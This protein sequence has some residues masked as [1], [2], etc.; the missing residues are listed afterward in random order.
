MCAQFREMDNN[1][2]SFVQVKKN[3][4]TFVNRVRR[5]ESEIN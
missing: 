3:V 2:N 1:G 5:N 4:F